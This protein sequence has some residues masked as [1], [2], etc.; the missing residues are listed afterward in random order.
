MRAQR[1]LRRGTRSASAETGFPDRIRA[2]QNLH[3]SAAFGYLAVMPVTVM[4]MWGQSD[5]KI[6]FRA[7]LFPRCLNVRADSDAFGSARAGAASG[8]ALSGGLAA[9]DFRCVESGSA[10]RQ[11]SRGG[12]R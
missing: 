11:A 6:E 4:P 9:L 3:R 5:R 10:S 2:G 7:D 1:L 8:G 12:A